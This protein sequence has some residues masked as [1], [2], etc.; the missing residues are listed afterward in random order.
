MKAVYRNIVFMATVALLMAAGIHFTQEF[1]FYN[2]ES[3]EL[4]LYDWSYIREM[5]CQ[6][7][8]AATLLGSL[9][10]Q[11]FRIPFAGTV[12]VSAV[13]IL[14]AWLMGCVLSRLSGTNVMKGI[15]FLPVAF[16]FLCME[17]DYYRFQGHVAFALM[18]A[19]VLAYASIRKEGLWRYLFGLAMIP[20]LFHAAGSVA[21]V[22]V[23]IGRAHV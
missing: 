9:L 1:R 7:G 19:A 6:T 5:I 21:V 20:V 13:Y 3:N 18:L 23:E 12:I 8:G 16:L 22:F 17:N 4:F 14:I 15:S 2:I 10:T 11:F